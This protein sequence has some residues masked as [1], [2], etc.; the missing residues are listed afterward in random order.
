MPARRPKSLL[1]RYK[2]YKAYREP[3]RYEKRLQALLEKKQKIE[4]LETLIKAY[5]KTD[6]GYAQTLSKRVNEVRQQLKVL[7]TIEP[8]NNLKPR[9][10]GKK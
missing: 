1:G 7:S 4:T 6:P 8:M 9:S 5:E 3:G 10:P 2:T